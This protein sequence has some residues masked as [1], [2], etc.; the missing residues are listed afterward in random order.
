MILYL[1]IFEQYVWISELHRKPCLMKWWSSFHNKKGTKLEDRLFCC[2]CSRWCLRNQSPET[3]GAKYRK[4][5]A[6]ELLFN[7]SPYESLIFWNRDYANIIKLVFCLSLCKVMFKKSITIWGIVRKQII[8]TLK[9]GYSVADL[10]DRAYSW[11]VKTFYK[12]K[13]MSHLDFNQTYLTIPV[14]PQSLY[15]KT[16]H[17]RP[18]WFWRVEF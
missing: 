12:G 17:L 9:A 16:I 8:K 6:K 15:S 18:I 11:I 3:S 7:L 2:L 1:S 5:I 4:V 13:K 10:K 14:P